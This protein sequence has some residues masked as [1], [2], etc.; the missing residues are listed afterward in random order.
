MTAALFV[1]LTFTATL[2]TNLPVAQISFDLALVFL[3]VAIGVAILKHRLYDIDVIINK[4][5]VYGIL[6]AFITVVYVAIVVVVGAFIGATQFL[7]LVATAIVAIAFQPARDRAKRTANRVIYGKR[8][9]P[10]EVLSGFSEHV[11]ETYGGEDILPRMARL[12][13]EGTGATDATVWLRVDDEMRPA[14][15]WPVPAA[16]ATRPSRRTDDGLPAFPDVDAAVAVRHGSDLLGALTVTKP[17]SDPILPEEDKL[18][19]D[20]AAQAGL[21]LENFRLDRGPA[22]VALSGWWRRRTRSAAVSNATS[23]TERSSSWWRWP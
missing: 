17:P 1:L 19:A 13:A 11:S 20:L 22:F 16:A 2:V 8:A 23:T 4:A 10:Y 21:V 15:S 5:V 14:A 12:L 6:G 18:L 3:Y 9:T 7:S